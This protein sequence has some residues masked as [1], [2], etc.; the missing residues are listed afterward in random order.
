MQMGMDKESGRDWDT[1]LWIEMDRDEIK[2]ETL[3][4][5]CV[6]TFCMSIVHHLHLYSIPN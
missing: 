6:F 5:V 3:Y 1:D 4:Y 2:V